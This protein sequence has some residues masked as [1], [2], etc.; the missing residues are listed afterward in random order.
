MT[1][2]IIENKAFIYVPKDKHMEEKKIYI[3]GAGLSGL[4]AAL[5]LE[6]V[7]FAPILLEATDR[8]GGRMKTEFFRAAGSFLLSLVARLSPARAMDGK[9][10]VAI[11]TVE[12]ASRLVSCCEKASETTNNAPNITSF[13]IRSLLRRYEAT[14]DFSYSTLY[15]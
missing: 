7:G 12:R 4:I 15:W 11:P 9:E 10:A 6:K 14:D 13:F 1:F 8:V 2:L 3:V 5:E